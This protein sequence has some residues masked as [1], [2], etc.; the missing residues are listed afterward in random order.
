M[1]KS[2]ELLTNK[3]YQ[4]PIV[5]LALL[6]IE[7]GFPFQRKL[8]SMKG[9]QAETIWARSGQGERPGREQLGGSGGIPPVNFENLSA[10]RRNLVH[11]Y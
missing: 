7:Q 1:E 8:K 6:R 5:F 9:K 3:T 2:I 4:E 11:F 10:L